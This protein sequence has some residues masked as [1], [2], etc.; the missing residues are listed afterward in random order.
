MKNS[1]FKLYAI[2]DN[3]LLKDKSMKEAVKEAMDGG[4][5]FLQLRDKMLG[6]EELRAEALELKELC[7]AVGI[8]FVINDYV[9]LA[10]EIDADGVH[11]GQSDMGIC[12]ARKILGK[13]KII[14]A[15]ARTVEDAL[16]AE[17]Q[18]ADYLGVGAMFSTS[19]KLDTK[20]VDYE[21]LKAICEAVRIPVV[22]IGGVSI[23][24]ISDLEGS[25]ISGAACVSAIFGEDN[26]EE[27]A[28]KLREKIEEIL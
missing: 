27:T 1:E 14:G 6:Y 17:S 13:D 12:E 24:N 25:G 9:E 11:V 21:T 20:H 22:A 10:R 19:T 28:K 5:T 26:I 4:I 23:D 2:T 7:K 3:R 18:G 8:P 16:K 15:S